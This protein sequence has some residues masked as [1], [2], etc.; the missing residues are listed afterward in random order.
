MRLWS[1]KE[2]SKGEMGENGGDDEEGEAVVKLPTLTSPAYRI[3]RLVLLLPGLLSSVSR[4]R[5]VATAGGETH[6]SAGTSRTS[7]TGLLLLLLRGVV[8]AVCCARGSWACRSGH[9]RSQLES[10]KRQSSSPRREG[11]RLLTPMTA[12]RLDC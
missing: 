5:K 12:V 6:I 8:S 11:K 7:L 1:L 4:G 10:P 9:F 2:K 3:I